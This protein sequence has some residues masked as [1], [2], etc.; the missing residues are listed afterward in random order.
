MIPRNK[1]TGFE[2]IQFSI[3]TPKEQEL[4]LLFPDLV[5]LYI[6]VNIIKNQLGI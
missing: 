6:P 1:A 3:R 5:N 4:S 2:R